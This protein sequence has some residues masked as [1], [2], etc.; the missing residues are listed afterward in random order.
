VCVSVRVCVCVHDRSF[1]LFMC[2]RVCVRECGA[3]LK[4][5][6]EVKSVCLLV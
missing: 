1:D 6:S 5:E 2:V 3:C 4:V